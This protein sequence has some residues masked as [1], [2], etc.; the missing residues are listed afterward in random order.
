LLVH[1]FWL[2]IVRSPTLATA[3]PSPTRRTAYLARAA[4]SCL[5]RLI[6]PRI[7]SAATEG[8]PVTQHDRTPPNVFR[9]CQIF[10]ESRWGSLLA[11]AEDCT[12][13]RGFIRST[14]SPES[15]QLLNHPPLPVPFFPA[16][17][18]RCPIA[19]SPEELLPSQGNE[20]P[21]G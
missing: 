2:R 17:P 9:T 11:I 19:V 21:L 13:A 1:R 16:P 18:E 12:T 15:P 4:H 6:F 5:W 14:L 3:M 10:P 8:T 7:T 20:F